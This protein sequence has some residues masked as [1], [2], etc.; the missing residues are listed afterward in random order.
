M[1]RPPI[2]Y[3]FNHSVDT[4]ARVFFCSLSRFRSAAETGLREVADTKR[5]VQSL[6]DNS[7]FNA[8]ACYNKTCK[9]FSTKCSVECSSVYD[10]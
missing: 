6:Q 2:L 9:L 8:Q 3:R 4:A 5:L 7:E 10:C 1:A